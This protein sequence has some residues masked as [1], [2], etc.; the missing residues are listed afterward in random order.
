MP[1][2][3]ALYEIDRAFGGHEEGGWFFDTGQ[4]VKILAVDR[5]E[6]RAYAR[7]DRL[8]QWLG[9]LQH[10]RRPV[11]SVAYNGGRYRVF[12]YQDVPP[13]FFPTERPTYE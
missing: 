1:T 6:H 4:L 12:T 3:L 10:Q 13:P 5:N 7:R 2:V 11:S 8:N 9:R